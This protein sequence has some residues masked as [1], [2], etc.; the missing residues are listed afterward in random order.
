MCVT[1]HNWDPI[2]TGRRAQTPF[3]AKGY[4]LDSRRKIDLKEAAEGPGLDSPAL[5]QTLVR[6]AFHGQCI[7]CDLSRRLGAG[8]PFRYRGGRSIQKIPSVIL[9]FYGATMSKEQQSHEAPETRHGTT[10]A[11]TTGI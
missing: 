6:E 5:P 10:G 3:C 2:L 7:S 1:S 9:H 4:V 11:S 8:I